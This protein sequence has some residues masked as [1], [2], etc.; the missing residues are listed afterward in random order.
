MGELG[1]GRPSTILKCTC[2]QTSGG[3][4]PSS[5]PLPNSR[6]RTSSLPPLPPSTVA[7]RASTSARTRPSTSR[8]L[9]TRR[10]RRRVS[11]S[12][13]LTPT[14]TACQLLA[15][16][17][18]LSSE[19][20][21]APTWLPTSSSTGSARASRFNSSVTV[22]PRAITPI[23]DIVNGVVRA[24]DRPYKYQ[25]FNLGKGSGTTLSE[26]IRIVEK[27]VGKS[28]NKVIL[29]DQ[30]GDVP[31]TCA[32]TEKA[33]A[34]LGYKAKTSFDEG[35]RRTVAWYNDANG[36][37]SSTKPTKTFVKS[38][39]ATN[40]VSEINLKDMGAEHMAA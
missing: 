20:G 34:L 5:R 1:L 24:I 30:P 26:F 37:V 40:F 10:R 25:V 36:I 11:S 19:K 27:Y 15:F 35:I 16:V 38:N 4:R 7:P 22:P 18:S 29:P 2:T 6:S 23:D 14:C 12:H 8:Y 33:R 28:A 3:P 17:S 32:S 21:A 31:R 39:I 13:T 9:L